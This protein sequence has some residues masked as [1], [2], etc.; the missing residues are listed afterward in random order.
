MACSS[1]MR[2]FQLQLHSCSMMTRQMQLRQPSG[3]GVTGKIPGFCLLVSYRTLAPVFA[4][5]VKNRCN[6]SQLER[7][8]QRR[9]MHSQRVT[10]ALLAAAGAA[11][12]LSVEV[13]KVPRTQMEPDV[14]VFEA[15][16]WARGERVK[17]DEPVDSHLLP[18][19][20]PLPVRE[21]PRRSRGP[22]RPGLAQLR[23]VA[24]R[25][26]RQR[27]CGKTNQCVATLSSRRR[28][29]GVEVDATISS[30]VK[31]RLKPSAEALEAVKNFVKAM[32]GVPAVDKF[33]SVV[34]T[35]V[36]SAKSVEEHRDRIAP[37]RPHGAQ[38]ASHSC[39]QG[40]LATRRTWR[41][42]C[43][44]SAIWSDSRA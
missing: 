13:K 7:L 3:S 31:A 28:V 39:G 17:G 22:Q 43:R 14:S 32:G 15:P 16:R 6:P 18:Q 30:Q 29:D 5:H 37:P 10:I 21:I 35:T 9:N 44:S 27:R 33:E 42:T 4:S 19:A 23:E 1:A 25:R 34:S 12:A 24:G 20:L 26:G 36:P 2:L 8:R 40:V 11:S 38:R 41:S